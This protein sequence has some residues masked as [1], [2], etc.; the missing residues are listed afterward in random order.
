MRKLLP[1]AP[2]AAL[3]LFA[4]ADC[5]KSKSNAA[6]SV[7]N[8]V[9]TNMAGMRTWQE[10]QVA[11][12]VDSLGVRHHDTTYTSFRTRIIPLSGTMI[13]FYFDSASTYADT[14]LSTPSNATG[15]M[16]FVKNITHSSGSGSNPTVATTYDSIAFNYY[17]AY[18]MQLYHLDALLENTIS[19]SSYTISHTP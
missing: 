14:I 10:M 9:D 8:S 4:L 18:S 17:G 11:G 1:M 16:S 2:L 12:S 13:I 15:V 5:K 6:P 19:D 7:N 3:L